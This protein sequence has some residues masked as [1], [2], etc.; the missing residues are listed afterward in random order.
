MLA[1]EVGGDGLPGVGERDLGGRLVEG[2]IE[3]GS[4]A[5]AAEPVDGAVMDDRADPGAQAPPLRPVGGRAPPD[6][7]ERLLDDVLGGTGVAEDAQGEREGEPPVPVVE[8]LDPLR[9]GLSNQVD[10][11]FVRRCHRLPC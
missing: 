10:D 7:E 1:L 5:A 4:A 8:H 11:P 3:T 6:R 2:E 9:R